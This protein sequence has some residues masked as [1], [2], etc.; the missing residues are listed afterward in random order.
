[1]EGDGTS[2]TAF[3]LIVIGA[4]CLYAF[5]LA[6][7]E[8]ILNSGSRDFESP[9]GLE[10]FGASGAR[11]IC[12]KIDFYLL[13]CHGGV[14]VSLLCAGINLA[15]A[16]YG[17]GPAAGLAERLGLPLLVSL[18]VLGLVYAFVAMLALQI[19]RA[20]AC[21][22]PEKA[23]C[24][25]AYPL[26][27]VGWL[28]RP[29]L[30]L[31]DRL[32]RSLLKLLR[33]PVPRG[34]ELAVSSEEISAIVERSSEA[35]EIEE[36]EGDMIQ[37]VIEFSDSVVREVMTP[38]KDIIAVEESA[39]LAAIVEIFTR[40]R[41]SRILVIGTDLDDVKGI[42]LAKDLLPY[43][44]KKVEEFDV[45]RYLR[46][47]YTV[48]ESKKTDE[49]LQEFRER[50]IHFAVALDEHG[51]VAGV[52][53]I[54]DLVE[55]IVGE[56]FDEFDKPEEEIGLRQTKSGDLI[57]HGSTILDDLNEEYAFDFPEG[58]YDTFAGFVIH[59]LGRIPS[60]GEV[61]QYNGITIKVEGVVGH[62]VTRL[63]ILNGRKS[64]PPAEIAARSAAVGAAA[65]SKL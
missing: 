9:E 24:V 54:E 35:G 49:L 33:L 25:V 40:E 39:S 46:P 15:L 13:L 20:A 7:A 4:T 29:V 2:L 60:P 3:L 30:V 5:F 61:I 12:A 50:A 47:P 17:A 58:E 42:L 21:A 44:G 1:M 28:C 56:I 16:A 10:Y 14:L 19:I 38:R 65:G 23:L 32:Q 63:R 55:E 36:E 41:L 37:G 52:V 53:T 22:N 27:F 57:V 6:G 18:P 64:A 8:A 34:L 62:R 48:P 11:R 26:L 45:R 59:Q 51:G 43:V 31:V